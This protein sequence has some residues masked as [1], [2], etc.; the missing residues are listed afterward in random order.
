MQNWVQ[1]GHVGSH[2]PILIFWTPNISG[3]KPARNFK[4]GTQM[5]GSEY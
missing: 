4:F 3:K 2:D 1:I 5:D